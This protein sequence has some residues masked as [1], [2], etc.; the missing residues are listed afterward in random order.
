MIKLAL[1][2]N[3]RADPV[4]D[5]QE[6][7]FLRLARRMRA[8][9]DLRQRRQPRTIIEI[10]RQIQ[11]QRIAQNR[12]DLHV[13]APAQAVSRQHAPF[14]H[15]YQ[16]DQADPD[17]IDAILWLVGLQQLLDAPGDR[18]QR[19]LRIGS[20]LDADLA[21]DPPRKI[22]HRDRVPPRAEINTNRIGLPRIQM[23]KTFFAPALRR[24]RSDA[25]LVD[26]LVLQESRHDLRY[27]RTFQPRDLS[28]VT[29]PDR[30]TLAPSGKPQHLI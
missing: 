1:N 8:Q 16:T 23:Q 21:Q 13:V 22:A 14:L 28:N 29:A 2:H 27:R 6:D 20:V 24:G 7:Q 17:P 9:P 18:F 25:V 12:S 10:E 5:F 30:L 4:A 11:I 3:S 26:K 19:L 15:I